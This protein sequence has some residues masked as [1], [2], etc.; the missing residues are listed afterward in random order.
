MAATDSNPAT[1]VERALNILENVAQRREGLTNSEIS[2]KLGIPKS[3]ASYILRTLERRGYLRRE[4]PTG[5]YKLG[6][7]ILS[8]GG[9]AQSNLDVAD[10]A[11]PFMRALVERVH[12]TSHLAV[13]DQGEAVYIEKV[14]A[15][16]FFKVNTWVGRRMYLHSTSVGKVL[17]AWLPRQEMEAIVRQ[18]GMKK[19]TPKTITAVSRLLADLE[20]VREQGYAV[21]DEENSTGARCLG[22]PIH[23]AM[24]S[25]TAALGVSGTLTQVDEENLSRI[26]DA[27]KET[28]RRISRQLIKSGASGAA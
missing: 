14:E 2:R 9:D 13:L 15:P 18:Q 24:G 8:L 17:L 10:V 28:A 26:A 12:L 1:A 22:A 23:D 25:V 3:S 27:L 6:L 16:G 4:G 5:R 20:L 11:L 19:R 21:D 7:K